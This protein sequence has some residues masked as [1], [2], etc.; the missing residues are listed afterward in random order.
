M[1]LGFAE[2]HFLFLISNEDEELNF[3]YII[4]NGIFNLRQDNNECYKILTKK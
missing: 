4:A 2:N 3:V 1:I